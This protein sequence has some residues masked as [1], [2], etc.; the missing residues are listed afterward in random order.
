MLERIIEGF[1][2]VICRDIMRNPQTCVQSNLLPLMYLSFTYHLTQP[3]MRAFRMLQLLA[4]VLYRLL[5]P[6]PHLCSGHLNGR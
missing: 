1:K 5:Q 2:C 3:P 6:N 4:T